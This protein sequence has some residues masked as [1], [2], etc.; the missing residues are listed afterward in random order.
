MPSIPQT[1]SHCKTPSLTTYVSPRARAVVDLLRQRDGAGCTARDIMAHVWGDHYLSAPWRNNFD[2]HM[3]MA[4][5]YAA[6]L[7][8]E[9]ANQRGVYFV[10]PAEDCHA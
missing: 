2:R 3:H 10:R 5:A 7:E 4:R 9:I 8:L 6:Y 1:T